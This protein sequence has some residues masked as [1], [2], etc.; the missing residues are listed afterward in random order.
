MAPRNTF[1]KIWDHH[2]VHAED[3][4]ATILYIDLHLVHEVTSPQAF[5]GLRQR[6][7]PVARPQQTI[8]T[9]DHNVPT[10]NQHLPIKEAL[11]RKQVDTLI[12]NCKEFGVELYGLGDRSCGLGRRSVGWILSQGRCASH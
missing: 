6:G 12:Q 9:A 10:E 11:S 3:A 2:V 5:A 1:Q 8:A 7:I 4:Q